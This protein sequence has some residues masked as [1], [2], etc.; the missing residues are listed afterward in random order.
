[1]D[2]T[3]DGRTV[4]RLEAWGAQGTSLDWNTAQLGSV[5]ATFEPRHHR[6]APGPTVAGHRRSPAE[7]AVPRAPLLV[8]A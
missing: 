3:P 5:R 6:T 4:T 1:M 2:T 8:G 7:V